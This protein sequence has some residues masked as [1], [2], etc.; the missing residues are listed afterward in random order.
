MRV[1]GFMVIGSMFALVAGGA[2]AAQTEAPPKVEAPQAPAALPA[3]AV[4]PIAVARE[5]V[6]AVA[7]AMSTAQA[8][9]LAI[10]TLQEK[11][12]AANAEAQRSFA[13]KESKEAARVSTAKP[14]RSEASDGK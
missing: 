9:A 5:D 6:Q 2:V 13:R 4:E 12:D 3:A 11:L 8:Y 7:Q 14:P 1:F 10:A